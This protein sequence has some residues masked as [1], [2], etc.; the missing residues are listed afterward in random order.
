MNF[1]NRIGI[2][3]VPVPL[4][5][6]VILLISKNAVLYIL[7][8]TQNCGILIVLIVILLSLPAVIHAED[9]MTWYSR[10]EDLAQ[11]GEYGAAI[12]SYSTA[13][14]L[15]PGYLNAWIGLG[16]AYTKSGQN[17]KAIDTYTHAISIE[18]NTSIAWK[19]LG[20]VYSTMGKDN[21]ALMAFEN[22]TTINPQDPYAWLSKGL[23]L[24]SMGRLN[25]S[26]AAYKT[27]IS[28]SPNDGSAWFS[29]GLDYYTLGNY[30]DA[31]GT[32]NNA[33]AIDDRNGDAWNYKGLTLHRLGRYQEA[34]EAF[35]RGLIIDPRNA[36]LTKNKEVSDAALR[37]Y[38]GEST[39][40]P[41][42]YLLLAAM[43][44]IA[45]GVVMFLWWRRDR[46]GRTRPVNG[47]ADIAF[48]SETA[49]SGSISRGS[50]PPP[51][52]HDVF[53]SYSSRDKPI[54][55]AVCASLEAKGNRCWVAPRD[56]LPGTNYPRAIV[57]AIESSRVM[58][59]IFSSHSNDSPHVVRELTHAVSKG[60]II[61]PFRIENIQPSKDMVYLIGI[62]HWLDAMTPPLESHITVLG[63]TVATLL[64][65]AKSTT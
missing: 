17:D 47:T 28:L 44:I 23:T 39:G 11:R 62:P 32:F 3:Q 41:V 52:P 2:I 9:A 19:S 22:A 37:S 63:E 45:C 46:P 13:L 56:V 18:P 50:S 49:S 30:T 5:V 36:E 6:V 59:L 14:S 51:I 57:E 33:L 24:S 43:G 16:Y 15:N 26:I 8:N 58:V 4:S 35:N 34:I 21:E 31:L 27:A 12:D 61:I 25:E 55:D 10:G 54:A 40:I 7:M 48:H 20:Y 42:I 64:S 53:I 60:V 38:V 29:L 1:Q 65:T